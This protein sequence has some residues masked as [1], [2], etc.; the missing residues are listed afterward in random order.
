MFTET[1][2][3]QLSPYFALLFLNANI[4]MYLNLYF[5]FCKLI[6]LSE[7]YSVTWEHFVFCS[8][9]KLGDS[10]LFVSCWFRLNTCIKLVLVSEVALLREVM[11]ASE[12]AFVSEVLLVSEDVL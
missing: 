9:N 5:R 7:I 2:T 1:D 12:V 4:R 6:S 8:A 3:S 10:L 11:L